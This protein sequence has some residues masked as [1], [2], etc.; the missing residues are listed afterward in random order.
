MAPKIAAAPRRIT[1]CNAAQQNVAPPAR[2]SAA[3]WPRVQAAAI[4]RIGKVDRHSRKGLERFQV[5]EC[6]R[7]A[8]RRCD[9]EHAAAGHRIGRIRRPGK[10]ARGELAR[11]YRPLTKLKTSPSEVPPPNAADAPEQ[12]ERRATSPSAHARAAVGGRKENTRGL[13]FCGTS[14]EQTGNQIERPAKKEKRHRRDHHQQRTH[15]ATN[16]QS[17][18]DG[19]VSSCALTQFGSARLR[20]FAFQAKSKRSP[21][22]GTNPVSTSMATLKIIRSC[23][24]AGRQGP[25]PGKAFPG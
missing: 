1:R 4:R 12:I 3:P 9:H 14:A 22:S 11:K 24:T 16:A 20:L 13:V 18:A 21:M 19:P 6:P 25:A 23:T 15:T 8:S 2:R 10:P 5:I 17:L 7:I